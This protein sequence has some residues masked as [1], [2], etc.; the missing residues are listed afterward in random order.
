MLRCEIF[1]ELR[2]RL[3]I[4]VLNSAQVSD[5]FVCC[6]VSNSTV[7]TNCHELLV[8]RCKQVKLS[9]FCDEN[10]SGNGKIFSRARPLTS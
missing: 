6:T 5:P 8:R 1:H 9:E 7:D 4:F 10:F 3:N 2:E